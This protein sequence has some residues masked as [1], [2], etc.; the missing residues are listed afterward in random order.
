LDSR[1][2]FSLAGFHF[3]FVVCIDKSDDLVLTAL[4]RTLISHFKR[5]KIFLKESFG[6]RTDHKEFYGQLLG[7]VRART[8]FKLDLIDSLN[9]ISRHSLLRKLKRISTFLTLLNLV[10]DGI[11]L[12]FSL[13]TGIQPAG[14]L[15]CVLL[16][17]MLDDFDR[18]FKVA[19]PTLLYCRF[20]N[21]AFVT[22]P[23]LSL[24]REDYEDE[25]LAML[26]QL[27][28]SGNIIPIELN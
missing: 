4:A 17:F 12:N 2:A 25:I 8:V 23:L 3:D 6:F 19:Y 10:P 20:M 27:C 14:I 7:V 1:P 15:A 9:T 21:E 18:L 13:D 5:S 24:E 28:L 26:S 22:F 11:N 16:H